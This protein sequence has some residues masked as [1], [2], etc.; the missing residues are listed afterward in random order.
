MR[1]APSRA[2]FPPLK[3]ARGELDRRAR[4]T[5]PTR[6]FGDNL[7]PETIA[8]AAA[9]TSVDAAMTTAAGE[10]I[11][12]RIAN[13]G[14]EMRV[15]AAPNGASRETALAAQMAA[16][17]AHRIGG[18]GDGGPIARHSIPALAMHWLQDHGQPREARTTPYASPC[19]AQVRI[20]RRI[21]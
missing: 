12:R 20:R 1:R 7:A 14:P 16:G 3:S 8:A 4:V 19:L 2:R 11:R 18:G 5:A 15:S 17:L 9:T 21:F 6:R 10:V 13:A